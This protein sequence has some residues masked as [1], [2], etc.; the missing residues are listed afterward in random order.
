VQT[1]SRGHVLPSPYSFPCLH[2]NDRLLTKETEK[3]TIA[4][5]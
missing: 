2:R 3:N 5:H 4:L 1:K